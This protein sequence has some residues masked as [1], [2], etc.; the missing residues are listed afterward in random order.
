MLTSY[1]LTNYPI[2]VHFEE[3][4]TASYLA[5]SHIITTGYLA[6]PHIITTGYLAKHTLLPLVIA[7]SDLVTTGYL[8]TPHL[9]TGYR[10]IPTWLLLVT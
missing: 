8:A 9:A 4:H 3:V 5:T 2:K 7:T 1:Q 6:T 10:A